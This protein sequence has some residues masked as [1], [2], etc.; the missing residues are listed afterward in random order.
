MKKNQN[1]GWQPPLSINPM[2][3]NSPVI[4]ID[5]QEEKHIAYYHYER[6]TLDNIEIYYLKVKNY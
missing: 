6:D 1:N 2:Y 4:T 5:N 3:G